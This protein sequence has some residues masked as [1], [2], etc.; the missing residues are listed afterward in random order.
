MAL[1]MCLE[2]DSDGGFSSDEWGSKDADDKMNDKLKRQNMSRCSLATTLL[3]L[4][5]RKKARQC[6]RHCLECCTTAVANV[7]EQQSSLS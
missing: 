2:D 7:T 1:P 3:A 5:H 6:S 4:C